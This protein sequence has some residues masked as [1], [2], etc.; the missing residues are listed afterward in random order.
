MNRE[1]VPHY[2]IGRYGEDL[3][4]KPK[5]FSTEYFIFK[6]S[7]LNNSQKEEITKIEKDLFLN[8]YCDYGNQEEIKKD[9]LKSLKLRAN[10]LSELFTFLV[11]QYLETKKRTYLQDGR[12]VLK[13]L[14]VLCLDGEQYQKWFVDYVHKN[15][16]EVNKY[17][18]KLISEYKREKKKEKCPC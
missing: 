2:F 3:S 13:D 7:V 1:I 10:N 16:T 6:S 15:L 12:S 9:D 11:C 17:R 8:L 18:N 4:I 5:N 14:D